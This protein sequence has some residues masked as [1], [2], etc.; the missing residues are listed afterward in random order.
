MEN[1]DGDSLVYRLGYRQESE[2]VWR[3]LG[4][5]DPLTKAEYDWNTDSV[6]DGLYLVRVW[7]TDERSNSSDRQL[8]S[9][10]VSAPFLV[11]NTRPEVRDLSV[12]ANSKPP[13]IVGRARD[14][15]SGHRARWN[16][17]STATTGDRPRPATACSISGWRTSPSAW[18]RTWPGP[19]RGQH[20]RLGRAPT[21][22]APDASRSRSSDRAP[23]ADTDGLP[24]A[25]EVV[26]LEVGL[27]QNFCE[28][29]YCPDTG[30]AAVVDPAFEVDRLLREAADVGRP[31]R[32]PS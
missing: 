2:A 24:A 6:P 19:P 16:I 22:W 3:P 29:L 9:T 18:A 30:E 10:F 15:G 8:D 21:T 25:P 1:P 31:H 7:V 11:D 20:P 5:P 4:G 32:R 17:R 23:S 13:V 28:I 26:Q 14:N 27:L 12:Q